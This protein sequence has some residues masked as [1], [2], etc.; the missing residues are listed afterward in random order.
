M[1]CFQYE[2]FYVLNIVYTRRKRSI[3]LKICVSCCGVFR[4]DLEVFSHTREKTVCVGFNT[5]IWSIFQ[6]SRYTDLSQAPLLNSSIND[7]LNAF[8]MPGTML[9]I[10]R[11]LLSQFHKQRKKLWKVNLPWIMLYRVRIHV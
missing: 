4:A 2:S 10:S 1:K 9:S 5:K 7:L 3:W 6:K 8:R 11:F